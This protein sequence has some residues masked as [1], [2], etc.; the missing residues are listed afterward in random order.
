[1][2]NI[3]VISQISYKFQVFGISNALTIGPTQY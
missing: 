2:P 3:I 1:M